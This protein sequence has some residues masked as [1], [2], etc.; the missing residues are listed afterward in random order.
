MLAVRTGRQAV[1][2]VEPAVVARRHRRRTGGLG[3]VDGRRRVHQE[4]AAEVVRLVGLGLVPVPD[5]AVPVLDEVGEQLDA[6]GVVGRHGQAVLHVGTT[7]QV[8]PPG[9]EARVDARLV[10]GADPPPPFLTKTWIRPSSLVVA[11]GCP[12]STDRS[13]PAFGLPSVLGLF[14]V[15]L[16][17][18]DVVVAVTTTCTRDE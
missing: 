18:L 12:I 6:P 1:E 14:E 16:G 13:V 5:L 10:G 17:R 3:L 2:H 9:V 8:L 15:H 11:T 4:F 7:A